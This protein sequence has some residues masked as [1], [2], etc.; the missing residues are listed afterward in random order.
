MLLF[1]QGCLHADRSRG[2]GG[3]YTKNICWCIGG[4]QGLVH[5]LLLWLGNSALYRDTTVFSIY[6]E[7]S[8]RFHRVI[9]KPVRCNKV[10]SV[11]HTRGDKDW[12]TANGCWMPSTVMLYMWLKSPSISANWRIFILQKLCNRNHK[13]T[14]IIII[15][16][17]YNPTNAI[18]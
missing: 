1:M 12:D 5:G 6:E 11:L 16:Y 14:Y 15:N 10:Y 3:A 8:N 9:H 13:N 2:F 7:N 18:L 17:Y 4:D